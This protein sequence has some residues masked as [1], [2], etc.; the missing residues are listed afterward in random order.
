MRTRIKICGITRPEAGVH[1]VNSGA[2]AIGLVFYDPSPR[3]V[4]IEQACKITTELPPFVTVVGL[5]VNASEAT[6]RRVIEQ[7]PISL[8][9]FH[10]NES[11][12]D[13]EL[14][15]KPY[16]KAVHMKEEV[17]FNAVEHHFGSARGL[18]LDSFK[19]DEPGGTGNRFNWDVIPDNLSRPIILA[20]GL[21]PENVGDAVTRIHPYAVDVSSGVESEKGI[22]D[23]GKVSRFIKAV[24]DADN[25]HNI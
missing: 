16:L 4:T 19:A 9:Q 10:G 23:P 22:K 6:V 14:Y 3:N 8:L 11:A 7:I 18:L 5:F 21:T 15:G 13:C 20:G 24:R 17:D 25:E 1:A 2:D 12:S